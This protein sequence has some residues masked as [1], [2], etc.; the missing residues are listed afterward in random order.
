[1]RRSALLRA[2]C[3]DGR[4]LALVGGYL[5]VASWLTFGDT[6]EPHRTTLFWAVQFPGDL[7]LFLSAL[8]L[9][10]LSRSDRLAHRFWRLFTVASVAFM[11]ADLLRTIEGLVGTETTEPGSV[12][13]TLFAI[14]Q[15]AVVLA[16]AGFPMLLGSGAARQRFL[17][18]AAIV[19]AGAAAAIWFLLTDPRAVAA[20]NS[21]V[22]GGLVIG[23]VVLLG[24]FVA[25]KLLLSGHSPVA[26]PAA[27][28]MIAAALVQVLP[29]AVLPAYATS[30]DT[31]ASL[32]VQLLSTVL[33][34]AGPRL[35]VLRL[36]MDPEARHETRRRP[37]SLL[38]Y[39]VVGA[40]QVLLF[41]AL[42]LDGDLTLRTWGMIVATCLVT[43]LVVIRQLLSVHENTRLIG[44]LDREKAW[45]GSLVAHS[46]DVTIVLDQENVIRYASPAVERVLGLRPDQLVGT[47]LR[48][49]MHPEDLDRLGRDWTALGDE[50]G[51]VLTVQVRLRTAERGWRWLEAVNT[52]LLHVPAIQGIVAN[53]RDVTEAREL[54]DQLRHQADHDVLTKLANRRLFT[55]RLTMVT[56]HG[57]DT[58][59]LLAIDLDGFK[60]INDR[61]GHHVGDA[62][63][64]AVAERIRR[65]V[66]PT[67]T[68]ARLGG[69]E[70]AVLMPGATHEAAGHLVARIEG[71]LSEPI[72]IGDLRLTIGASIGVTVGSPDDPDGLLRA[73]D[74]A[75]YAVK[76][77]RGP[78]DLVR[79]R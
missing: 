3:T 27:A 48:D 42:W 51:R 10:R 41:V 20:A 71:V 12:Q 52:N 31:G 47:R 26:P 77:R 11:S 53:C 33:I 23:A 25:V 72:G 6:P 32:S 13:L 37:Y 35:E 29:I 24:G 55:E 79:Q 68:A 1:M 73:A 40:V 54:Q 21:D 9:V 76:H 19:L 43:G 66:R 70:F 63:L 4:L 74:A 50:P 60:P 75:M 17:L 38:P 46:S 36:R 30:L 14:G 39:L 8:T 78:Q 15:T 16:L 49:L 57:T 67:D 2:A 59:A 56:R 44:Q 18:D 65:C 61:H 45:F 28:A 58:V 22:V 69:D 7:L 64:V 5:L 34:A 62:V